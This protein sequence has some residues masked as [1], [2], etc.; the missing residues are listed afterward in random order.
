MGA[1]PRRIWFVR[2]ISNLNRTRQTTCLDHAC[3]SFDVDRRNYSCLWKRFQLPI[4]FTGDF[5][6]LCYC[7]Y[8]L[9]LF[10]RNLFDA[11]SPLR[12]N[13]PKL[14]FPVTHTRGNPVAELRTSFMA[15]CQFQSSGTRDHGVHTGC[16][17]ITN[18]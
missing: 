14:F 3:R 1:A 11:A 10:L 12:R 17:F 6:F 18:N 5:C 13:G 15:L 2:G 16:Y 8:F 9:V 7:L 4:F